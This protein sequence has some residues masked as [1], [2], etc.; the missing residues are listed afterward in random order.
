MDLQSSQPLP[1]TLLSSADVKA[2]GEVA[3]LAKSFE[4]LYVSLADN[5]SMIKGV[6]ARRIFVKDTEGNVKANL[7]VRLEFSQLQV[8][9]I[10]DQLLTE[11]PHHRVHYL[12]SDLH[13]AAQQYEESLRLLNRL[14]K[15]KIVLIDQLMNQ[16]E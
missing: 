13:R 15:Q 12:H 16:F 1:L 14:R 2:K 8:T 10:I 11:A 4:A 3:T 5:E 6:M 9:R 7:P